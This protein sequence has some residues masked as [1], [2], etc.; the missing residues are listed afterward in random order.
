MVGVG[1]ATVV[2]G[3]GSVVVVGGGIEIMGDV[4]I[5][6]AD[7]VLG[8][9]GVVM[10]TRVGI[11]TIGWFACIVW[12]ACVDM[13]MASAAFTRSATCPMSTGFDS[14]NFCSKATS[15]DMNPGFGLIQ[16]L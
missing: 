13:C 5:V 7:S 14:A 4:E 11:G 12:V 9:V 8:S 16:L 1:C 10:G 3:V 15:C 2:I 6:G